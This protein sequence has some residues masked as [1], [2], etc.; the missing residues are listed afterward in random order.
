MLNHTDCGMLDD[1]VFASGEAEG[2]YFDY[3][4]YPNSNLADSRTGP[5]EMP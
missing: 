4:D 1:M 2:N 3:H 5:F